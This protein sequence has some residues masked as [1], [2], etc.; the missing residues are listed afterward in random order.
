MGTFGGMGR[1]Y[2]RG[3]RR[4]RRRVLKA[5][6]ASFVLQ[7]CQR[8]VAGIVVLQGRHRRSVVRRRRSRLFN[9]SSLKEFHNSSLNLRQIY[10]IIYVTSST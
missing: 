1:C 2:S 3:R 9:L 4:E 10:E 5:E 6:R 7:A 8:G